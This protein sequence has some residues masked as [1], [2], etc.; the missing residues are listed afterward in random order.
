MKLPNP[1]DGKPYDR[2]VKDEDGNSLYGY[3]N[4]GTGEEEIVHIPTNV[5]NH[6]Y[7]K[8]EVVLNPEGCDHIFEVI[9]IGKREVECKRCHLTTSFVPGVSFQES[10]NSAKILLNH[11]WFE[12]KI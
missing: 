4:E 2:V 5:S 12:V 10:G 3:R 1:N 9:D 8:P 7:Y 6:R 11:V